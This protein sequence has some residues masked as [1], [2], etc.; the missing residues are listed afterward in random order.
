MNDNAKE[1]FVFFY[2][3]LNSHGILQQSTY[4]HSHHKNGMA[5]RKDR[6]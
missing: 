4:I 2:T 1:C 5:E 6:L 3:L